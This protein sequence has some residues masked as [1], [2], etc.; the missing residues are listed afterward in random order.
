MAMQDTI[1]R[2]M[3]RDDLIGAIGIYLKLAYPSGRWPDVVERRLNLIEQ[4]PLAQILDRRPF[5]KST[6][7][8]INSGSIYSLRLGNEFYPCMKLQIQPWPNLATYLLS[9]N[10]HDEVASSLCASTSMANPDHEAF[11]VLQQRN[12]ALKEAIEQAWDSAGL[13]TFHRYMQN[14]LTASAAVPEPEAVLGPEA[15]TGAV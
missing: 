6:R 9:V 1:A 12:Q 4:G 2:E 3:T 8:T 11:Q 5:E 10:T 14:Y 13:P 7:L 15:P